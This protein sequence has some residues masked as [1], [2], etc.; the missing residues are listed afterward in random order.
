MDV[1]GGHRLVT[2]PAV[3]RPEGDAEDGDPVDV[4]V[5]RWLLRARPRRA[6]NST[7][8]TATPF[9]PD[10]LEH[11]AAAGRHPAGGAAPPGPAHGAGHRLRRR[12][13]P[14]LFVAHTLFFFGGLLPLAFLVYSGRPAGRPPAVVVLA[15]PVALLAVYPIHVPPLRR[16]RLRLRGGPVRR[17]LRGRAAGAPARAAAAAACRCPGRAVPR[18][19]GPR[20]GA[21]AR[22][23]GRIARELHDVVAHAVSVMVVQAGAARFALGTDEGEVRERLLSVEGTGRSAVEDLRRLLHLLRADDDAPQ[24]AGPEPGLGAAGRAGRRAPARRAP[25][26]PGDAARCPPTCRR[27]STSRPTGWCRRR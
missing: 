17:R 20:T 10:A 16:R 19:G 8:T 3:E 18:A 11:P 25:G 2:V 4:A 27:C 5:A 1:T 21:A 22:R 9:G 6:S 7:G 15:G 23:A 24:D 14:S 26:P 13:R 12:R